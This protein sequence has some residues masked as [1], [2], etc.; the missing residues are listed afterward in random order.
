MQNFLRVGVDSFGH[1]DEFALDSQTRLNE[2]NHFLFADYRQTALGCGFRVRLYHISNSRTVE[3][4]QPD[5]VCLWNKEQSEH[6][7]C[8][9]NCVNGG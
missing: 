8:S 7:S 3:I 1:I 9:V 2:L 5:V 4:F 6:C